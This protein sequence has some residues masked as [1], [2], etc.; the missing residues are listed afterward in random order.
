MKKLIIGIDPGATT[1]ISAIDF[2]SHFV[3][4]VSRKE[5]SRDDIIYEIARL[6]DPIVITTDK[7]KVPSLVRHIASAFGSKIISPRKDMTTAEKKALAMGYEGHL[8]NVHEKDAL[9]AALSSFNQIRQKVRRIDKILN[10]KALNNLKEDVLTLVFKNGFKISEAVAFLAGE[11]KRRALATKAKRVIRQIVVVP[12]RMQALEKELKQAKQANKILEDRLNKLKMQNDELRA[13]VKKT[14]IKRGGSKKVAQLRKQLN[15]MKRK[16]E[17]DKKTYEREREELL[18][19]YEPVIV[20]KDLSKAELMM[21]GKIEGK[22][23]FVEKLRGNANYLEQRAPRLIISPDS[24]H[25]KV[26]IPVVKNVKGFREKIKKIGGTFFVSRL[27]IK[28]LME[29]HLKTWFQDWIKSYKRR[30]DE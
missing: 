1:A 21:A 11:K 9:A 5:F 27:D 20:L 30:M 15:T 23:L 24:G 7:K 8:E 12:R 29:K 4:A 19:A 28:N 26:T 18:Q 2:D 10:E 17:E 22:I 16:Y 3:G 13:V 14:G 25:L 6:G